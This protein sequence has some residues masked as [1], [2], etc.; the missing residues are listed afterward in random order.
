MK[1]KLERRSESG[2][3]NSFFI[4]LFSLIITLLVFSILLWLE[5]VPILNAWKRFLL[6]GFARGRGQIITINRTAV[7]ILLTL[8][9]II[10]KKAGVWNVGGQG[11]FCMGAVGATGV[12][13]AFP[14]LP[15]F[16]MVPSMIIA[17]VIMGMGWASIAGF[18]KSK[19]GANEILLT[20][21]MNFVAIFIV[22]YL[23]IGG[24]WT[25][26]AGRPEGF[27]LPT[28]SVMPKMLGTPYSFTLVIAIMIAVFAYILINKTKTGFRI[29]AFG[30]DPAST[31]RAGIAGWKIILLVFVLAGGIAG[32]A[33]YQQL[34]T[35]TQNLRADIGES[36]AYYAIVFGLLANEDT[37]AVIPISFLVVGLMVGTHS[38]Q[39]WKNVP[40]GVE[41]A[42]I[43][44]LFL[45]FV[46]LTFFRRFKIRLE[47]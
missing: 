4:T 19:F 1:I 7:F 47:W 18:A 31:E 28:S 16:I 44:L 24:P 36:W 33:G 5:G 41:A 42:F 32:F 9:F 46:F 29:R 40:F 26:P 15:K 38:L 30:A 10:P 13:A 43:G 17:A 20:L 3:K 11:Q 39:M 21:M 45:V 22:K 34:T 37:I 6:F 12:A 14:H 25:T 27:L 8:A 23:V 35:G 2:A